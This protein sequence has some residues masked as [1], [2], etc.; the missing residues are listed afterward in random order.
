MGFSTRR[1][2]PSRRLSA[3]AFGLAAAAAAFAAGAAAGDA[4]AGDGGAPAAPGAAHDAATIRYDRD[5]RPLLSDRCFKC[6][7][8]DESKRKAKLR[9]DDAASAGEAHARG[10]LIVPA[11]PEASELLNRIASD[12]PKRLMPPPGSNK[13][14][15]HPEEQA[16]LRRWIE[17]GAKYEEH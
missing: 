3:L 10:S 11:T 2:A 17:Q 7:G 8:R 5:V 14:P 12:D 4:P 15:F 9:L 16:L 1:L 13:R 6:H